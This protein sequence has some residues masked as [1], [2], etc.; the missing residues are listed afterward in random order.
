MKCALNGVGMFN[1]SSIALFSGGFFDGSLN[2]QAILF[3]ISRI[4]IAD[5][6]IDFLFASQC[7]FGFAALSVSGRRDGELIRAVIEL[8]RFRI[9]IEEFNGKGGAVSGDLNLE[10]ESAGP[11]TEQI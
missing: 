11:G 10:S 7:N 9:G 1:A 6:H 8:E 3:Q 2:F 4:G 5:A